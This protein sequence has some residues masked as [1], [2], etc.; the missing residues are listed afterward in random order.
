MTPDPID[1][2]R[3]TILH[4]TEAVA[5]VMFLGMIAVFCALASGA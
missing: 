5:V 4:L 2:L 3:T 1:I